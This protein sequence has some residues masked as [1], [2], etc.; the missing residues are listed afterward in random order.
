MS[1]DTDRGEAMPTDLTGHDMRDG[2]LTDIQQRIGRGEYRVDTQAVASAILRR[3]L[4]GGEP[5]GG[6]PP[7]EPCS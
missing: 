5:P 3:L 2:R 4:A 7:Q 1:A 6:R